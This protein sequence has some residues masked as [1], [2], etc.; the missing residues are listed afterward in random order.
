[1][2][3]RNCDKDDLSDLALFCCGVIAAWCVWMFLADQCACM[4][5]A[6]AEEPNHGAVIELYSSPEDYY[7]L[8]R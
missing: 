4:K 6:A 3:Q 5:Q 1:M 8:A 7:E 2:A